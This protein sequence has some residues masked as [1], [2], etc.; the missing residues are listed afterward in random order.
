MGWGVGLGLGLAL[1]VSGLLLYFHRPE[2]QFFYP[3][4][5]FHE[6][7]GWLCPGCGGLR[8]VHALMHGRLGEAARCNALFVIGTPPVAAWWGWHRFRTGRGPAFGQR[9]VWWLFAISMVFTVVRNLP[10][11]AASWLLP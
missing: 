4:C 9:C 7:T 10:V 8:S 3:R 6:M 1:A 5:S 2:G 11:R